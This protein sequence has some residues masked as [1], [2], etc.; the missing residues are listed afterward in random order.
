M[1]NFPGNTLLQIL[2]LIFIL[3]GLVFGQDEP[4]QPKLGTDSTKSGY[5]ATYR[6]GT[7]MNKDLEMELDDYTAPYYR[8]DL[9][10]TVPWFEFKRRLN[11]NT[12][13]QLSFNYSSMFIGA[14]DV[15]A[16]GNQRTAASGIFDA[17]VKWTFIGR[18][19][20]KN[21]GSLVWW[22]D[23]RHLYYGDVAP[24][25]H[26][27]ETG[28]ATMGALKFNKWVIHTLEFYYQQSLFSGRMGLVIGK[29]DMPDWF[30]YHGLLHP[31]LH[32]MDFA[33]S[34]NPTVS[35]SNPGMGVVLGGWLN[36]DKQ[37][38]LMIGLND[39]AGTDISDPPFFNLGFDQWKNGKFLKM[40]EFI[41]TPSY[42]RFYYNRISLTIWHSDELLESDESFFTS[43][44]SKGFSLQGTWV[45]E[46]KFIPTVT[47]GLSDGDGA[48]A[49]SRINLSLMHAWYF[50]SH[51]LFAIG[52]NYTESTITG[53]NQF[54][55][56]VFYR[57]TLSKAISLT[58][59]VKFVINPALNE[60]T[61]FLFYYGLRSRIS[62]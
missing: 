45:I 37:F 46:D 61:N 13:L 15:I 42:D 22:I 29:I 6:M 23:S 3:T 24:Q 10:Y 17:T 14:S 20:G 25:F 62:M 49:L 43:P 31:M 59:M 26:F 9:V 56:E 32:F 40:V 41:Y 44:S 58:P 54:L 11:E 52:L 47:F 18:K 28:S 35:W 57:F 16:D 39:V 36:K 1:T 2:F 12:G 34:V 8:F 51:D 53:N 30:T 38:G 50:L 21:Q 7:M 27:M 60:N 4:K 19:S 48:N 33:F 55:S 5:R